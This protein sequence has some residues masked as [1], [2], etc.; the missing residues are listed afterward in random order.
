LTGF[1]LSLV[2]LVAGVT[3]LHQPCPIPPDDAGHHYS[4]YEPSTRTI[5][6]SHRDERAGAYPLLHEYGHA[7][8]FERLTDADRSRI[9]R[10][11]GYRQS[12]GWWSETEQDRETGMEKPGEVFADAYAY[13]AM[14]SRQ[15]K[16]RI[17]A[18][19]PPSATAIAA[20]WL[21]GFVHPPGR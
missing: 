16:W 5:Y 2:Q 15:R 6:L 10:I 3:V 1:V 9:K 12:R 20:R 11:L 19:L 21:Q 8:D 17:C 13:C 7:W 14:G 18:M 4:C